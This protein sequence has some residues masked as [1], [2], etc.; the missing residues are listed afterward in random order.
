MPA[1][2]AAVAQAFPDS[3]R[4]VGA[5]PA[6][7]LVQ[8]H[9][10]ITA[11][12]GCAAAAAWTQFASGRR[13]SGGL[14]ALGEQLAVLEAHPPYVGAGDLEALGGQLAQLTASV[15]AFLEQPPDPAGLSRL[16]AELRRQAEQL[17]A[18]VAE[19]SGAAAG[20]CTLAGI[21]RKALAGLLWL[22]TRPE[23]GVL[24]AWHTA[25]TRPAEPLLTVVTARLQ[26][27]ELT[28][29]AQV[30]NP[31]HAAAID[32]L[33]IATNDAEVTLG[34]LQLA[35][36]TAAR[37]RADGLALAPRGTVQVRF[38][39][40][41]APEQLARWAAQDTMEGILSL[42]VQYCRAPGD[43]PTRALSAPLRVRY[44]APATIDWVRDLPAAWQRITQ[45]IGQAIALG[46]SNGSY[47]PLFITCPPLARTD[48]LDHL[49]QRSNAASLP[50]VIDMRQALH[51][52]H[53]QRSKGLKT[54]E[55]DW[56]A[57]LAEAIWPA[58]APLE[59][60]AI[61]LEGTPRRHF[62][63]LAAGQRAG[64]P[65]LLVLNN[66]E[67]LLF[68]LARDSQN[69]WAPLDQG[70]P[71]LV[72]WAR[73]AKVQ[74]VFVGTALA[75]AISRRRWPALLAAMQP[76]DCD[77]PD[78]ENAALRR[79]TERMVLRLLEDLDLSATLRRF[80]PAITAVDLVALAGG[81]LHILDLLLLPALR[82]LRDDPALQ[83]GNAADYLLACATRSNFFSSFW[84][85][86]SFFE[87]LALIL[88]THG[89]IPLQDRT[90]AE[91]GLTLS[92]DYFGRREHA[93][94]RAAT[95]PAGQTLTQREVVTIHTNRT[96]TAG[97][98]SIRGLSPQQPAVAEWG[99]AGEMALNLLHAAGGERLLQRL[100]SQGMVRRRQSRFLGDFY[101]SGI[102]LYDAWLR[103]SGIWRQMLAAAQS[104]QATWYPVRLA[105]DLR[106]AEAPDVPLYPLLPVGPAFHDIP[107]AGLQA[108]QW[109]LNSRTLPHFL[110]FYGFGGLGATAA[111]A[112]WQVLVDL[113]A[114]LQRWQQA[115]AEEPPARD[116]A[117]RLFGSLRGALD[118]RALPGMDSAVEA[119]QL[120]RLPAEDGQLLPVGEV[121]LTAASGAL[122]KTLALLVIADG[123][124]LAPHSADLRRWARARLEAGGAQAKRWNG[125]WLCSWCC[126]G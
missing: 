106:R 76:V 60:A 53:E 26:R 16:M 35:C 125:A 33:R 65:D 50:P 12:A 119:V 59:V 104:P 80:D 58:A 121:I 84:L 23:H 34:S 95:L 54:G 5:T 1:L 98:V 108:V 87:R 39:A 93:P 72:S 73:G 46:S 32:E 116:E 91:S 57:W 45:E 61:R 27:G 56:L 115:A 52:L 3:G 75:G 88:V 4:S 63:N 36:R 67:S 78:D 114:A 90:W 41:L 113:G 21:C 71:F 9:A 13:R 48:L 11:G 7:A 118:V 6:D 22:W 81:S 19:D 17:V 107:L 105:L 99:V 31:S 70:L 96:F 110:N 18:T 126:R 109:S 68:G 69:L 85:W 101:E 117:L 29:T 66:W 103:Q 30:D 100:V 79:E 83:P 86:Q 92:R 15:A 8:F 120:Q 74:L 82:A 20:G 62:S 42:P 55:S 122:R 44:S 28:V 24:S 51:A 47:R 102:P 14:P 37:S 94:G 43:W 38:V 97:D 10:L 123:A 111:Q 112:R 40:V 124:A 2:A 89:E 77:Y 25:L 64:G 49:Q